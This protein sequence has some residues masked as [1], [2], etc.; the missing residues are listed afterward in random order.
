MARADMIEAVAIGF[1]S[2]KIPE[3]LRKL[4]SE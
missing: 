4:R 3:L 1:G 2:K